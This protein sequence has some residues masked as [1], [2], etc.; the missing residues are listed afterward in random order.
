MIRLATLIL[1]LLTGVGSAM[2]IKREDLVGAWTYIESYSEFPDGKREVLFGEKPEGIFIILPNG[3][4]SHIIMSPDLPKIKSGRFLDSTISEA[5]KIAEG[6]LAHF[7]T[8]TIDEKLGKFTV[9]IHKSSFP[10]IDGARQVRTVT[11]LDR[12]F[13]SYI[14]DLSVVDINRGVRV[15]AQLRRVWP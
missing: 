3:R 15:K 9:I 6:V 4:Y 5:E 14:N 12:E 11:Q 8:W 1:L 13:L 7:G 10:N 2:E